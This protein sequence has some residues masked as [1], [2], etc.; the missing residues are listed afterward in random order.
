MKRGLLIAFIAITLISFVSAA[1]YGSY[2]RFSFSD[3]LDEV[4]SSTMI[5]GTLFIIFFA[6][7]NYALARVFKDNKAIAGVISFAISLLIVWGVNNSNLDLESFF[8][9]IGFSDNFLFVILPILVIAGLVI[10]IWKFKLKRVLIGFGA[11]L[12]VLSFT[13]FIYTKGITLAIG[14]GC[15]GLGVWLLKR[16]KPPKHSDHPPYY[17]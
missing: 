7:I 2:T 16:K 17:H 5:L 9:D 11:L 15:L 3:L 6:M 8:Y 1:Y 10:L 12:V 13:D 4:D 14:I